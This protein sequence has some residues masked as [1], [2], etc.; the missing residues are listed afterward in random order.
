MKVKTLSIDKSK[1][2]ESVPLR[3]K[4]RSSSSTSETEIVATAV[5]FSATCIVDAVSIEGASFTASIVTV[6]SALEVLFP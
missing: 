1:L 4:V 6:T 3:V 2:S 5:W